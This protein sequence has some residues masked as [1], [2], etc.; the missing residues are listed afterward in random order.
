MDQTKKIRSAKVPRRANII[1]SL[2]DLGNSAQKSITSDIFEGIPKSA[3]DQLFSNQDKNYSGEITPG[4]NLNM[5]E[6]FS[7]QREENEKL[8]KQIAFERKLSDEENTQSEK[9]INE[10]RLQLHALMEEVKKLALSTQEMGEQVKI[11]SLQA[12]VNPGVYHLVFFEKLLEFVQNFRKKVENA[13]IWLEST[14]K[15]AEK[16][17]FW[18][19]YKKSGSKFLLSPDHYSQRSAG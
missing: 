5:D 16:K 19:M 4:E 6:V 17:N 3:L 11:A 7:G 12:P 15:K 8:S 10:L 9:K 18:T 2:K 14:N 13:E 1:E